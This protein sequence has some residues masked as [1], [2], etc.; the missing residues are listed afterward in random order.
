VR[1][2]D[3]AVIGDTMTAALIGRDGSMDWLCLPRFDSTSC[4]ARLLGDDEHGHWTVRPAGDVTATRRSYRGDTL[5][6]ETEHDTTDGTVRVTDFMPVRGEHADIMRMVEGVRGSVPM[7][8]ELVVRFEYGRTVPWVRRLDNGALALVAGPD[9]LYLHTPVETRGEGLK[10][11]ADFV[12]AEGE[13]VSFAL[14]WDQSHHPPPEPADCLRALAETVDFWTEWSER[15]RYEGH[16]GDAVHR[17][18]LTLKALT[19][20]PT[21]GIVAAPTT[22]LPEQ[23]GG[24]RNWDYRYCWLRDATFTLQSLMIAGYTEEA[25]AWRDWLLRAVAGMPSEMQT[26]YGPAGE[27]RIPEW[28]ADWLPGYEGSRPVR[29]GN[30]AVEQFQ[31]DVYGEVMDALHQARRAGIDNDGPSWE[32]QLELMTFLTGAWREPDE[33]IWEVRGPRRHFVHSKVLAW[34]AFD[35]AVKAVEQHGRSGPV[36]AWRATR[37][38]IHAEVCA[39][40][41]DAERNTFVQYYGAR[42][43]DAAL[44]QLPLVGFLP[45]DDPRI[46]GTVATIQHDLCENGLVRRYRTDE[47]EVDGLPPGEGAFLACSFWLVDNLAMLGRH[48]EAVG[49]FEHVLSLRNDI[50]LLGE[51]YDT[52]LGRQVGNFPQAFSHVALVNAAY[53]LSHELDN[54]HHRHD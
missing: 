34:V 39:R 44:L 12:V 24:V 36:E 31:L 47:S 18:L 6:L 35:R 41:F 19:Y 29:L 13:R 8:M 10:T 30:A 27:R 7:R 40:G 5:V 4:F 33:G 45:I 48:D 42:E 21:G 1:I 50:G 16:W 54:V 9:A 23:V 53:G 43:V 25:A 37:D 38:E 28:E 15:S 14:M 2:E 32:F 22:S 49:L 3:Y 11:V 17:S 46:V 26:M 51:E 20:Q 52:S